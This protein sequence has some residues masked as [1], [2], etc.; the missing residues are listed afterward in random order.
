MALVTEL[1]NIRQQT[2]AI[3]ARAVELF[4]GLSEEQLAWRPGPSRWCIA[5]NLLHLERTVLIF[6][7]VIDR[8]IENARRKRP[9]KQWPFSSWPHGQI[10]RLVCRTAGSHPALRAET[11]GALA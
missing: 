4:A 8:A 7:P 2:D 11:A 1:E 5:E 10:L 9:P 6:L 3:S